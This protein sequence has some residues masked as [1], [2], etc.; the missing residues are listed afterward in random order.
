MD[1]IVGALHGFAEMSTLAADSCSGSGTTLNSCSCTGGLLSCTTAG[2]LKV[3]A[4]G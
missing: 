3:P 4:V 1:W 2:A